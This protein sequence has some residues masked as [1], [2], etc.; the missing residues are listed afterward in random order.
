MSDGQAST[1]SSPKG[2]KCKKRKKRKR[3][4]K[5]ERECDAQRKGLRLGNNGRVREN[6]LSN[7]FEKD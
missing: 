5:R 2:Q 4:K 7:G 1:V 3:R 6:D